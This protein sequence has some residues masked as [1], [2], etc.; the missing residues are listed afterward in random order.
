MSERG[1]RAWLWTSGALTGGLLIGLAWS[2]LGADKTALWRAVAGC[3]GL[4]GIVLGLRTA[5]RLRNGDGEGVLVLGASAMAVKLIEE[6][7]ASGDRRFRLVGAIDDSDGDT[8]VRGVAPVLGRLDDFARAVAVTRPRRIILAMSD[9]RGRVPERALL[10]SRFNGVIIE[11]VVDFFERV[12]GKLAIEAI[13]PSAL[14]MATGFGHSDF[15]RSVAVQRVRGAVCRGLALVGLVLAAPVLILIAVAIKLDSPGSVL[16]V[17]DRIGRGGRPFGLVKFRTMR[18]ECGPRKSEW[19]SDNTTRITRVGRWL[20][21]F[22]LDELPQLVNVVRGEM[23]IVGP[24][25]HPVA[26]YEL[27]LRHIPYYEFRSLVRPGITGW[28]QVRYGYANGLEEETEKM[29]YDFYYIKHRCLRLDLRII[30]QTLGVLL[31]DKRSHQ[32][33]KPRPSP[34]RVPDLNTAS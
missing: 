9:R 24:R 18:D 23:N 33:A 29:R 5:S 28:A 20:R 14:I 2:G 8:R 32:A 16:F 26:N 1:T 30:L 12:T 31:F 17:Q 13:R 27:F 7:E 19:V 22:R 10:E 3:A 4:T 25:P 15:A 11:D 6:M 21:R 34:N